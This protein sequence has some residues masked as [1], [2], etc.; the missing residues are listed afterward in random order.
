MDLLVVDDSDIIRKSSQILLSKI[1]FGREKMRLVDQASRALIECRVTQ[2]DIMIIDY[3]LGEGSTG[4]QLLEKLYHEQLLDHDPIILIVTADNS[5]T[6]IR[7]FSEFELSGF[8][9][10]PLRADV[11][12]ESLQACM[13][14]K[15]YIERVIKSYHQSGLA[16]A[17]PELKEAKNK[18]TYS[19]ALTKLC[20]EI[21]LNGEA[22]IASRLLINYIKTNNFVRAHILYIEIMLKEGNLEEVE[23]VL[24]P[25]RKAN[26]FSVPV[27]ELECR[28]LFEQGRYEQAEE[29]MLHL[30][31]M[32]PQRLPR[33]YALILQ[34]IKF[35]PNVNIVKL[36][37][38]LASKSRNSIWEEPN[39]YFI[40]SW[41]LFQDGEL[42]KRSVKDIWAMLSRNKKF[43]KSDA[44]LLSRLEV[45]HY[46]N[47]GQYA[48]A[49]RQLL[50]CEEL[51]ECFETLFVTYQTYHTLGM[52]QETQH[53]LQKLVS[54]AEQEPQP[55]LRDIENKIVKKLI[56]EWRSQKST[57]VTFPKSFDGLPIEYLFKLWNDYR[58]NIRI[59]EQ[60]ASHV[61]YKKLE[62]TSDKKDLVDEIKLTIDSQVLS[63]EEVN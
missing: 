8:I 27:L 22:G 30:H 10:K 20:T 42:S 6:V 44:S 41:I 14:E 50:S 24:T 2:F 25:L 56:V 9:V 31:K 21:E 16:A 57:L 55:L 34:H 43:T 40:L 19:L 3:N 15:A 46:A 12:S 1:G 45:W 35:L 63:V 48:T 4:L 17:L 38:E 26:R 51:E 23:R 29:C 39:L 36:V 37:Q 52:W 18:K 47:N 13:D 32:C 54:I 59:A 49:Y 58:F 5:A 7:S 33:L 60:I 61:D 53:I 11:L 28:V 62:A